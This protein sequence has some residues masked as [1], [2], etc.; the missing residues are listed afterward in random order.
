[1]NSN[2]MELAISCLKASARL[3]VSTQ[4]QAKSKPWAFAFSSESLDLYTFTLH[5]LTDC[6]SNIHAYKIRTVKVLKLKPTIK[7]AHV[8]RTFRRR[9]PSCTTRL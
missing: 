3:A 2:F 6:C 9:T 7:L 8:Y 5:I 1:M 4:F